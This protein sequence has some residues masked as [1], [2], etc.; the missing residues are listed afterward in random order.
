MRTGFADPIAPKPGKKKK[1]PWNF[2]CPPYDE[3]SSCYVNAG[4]HWGLGHRNPVGHKGNPTS[5]V[6]TLPRGRP[7]TMKVTEIPTAN[8][9][10]E[11]L[12]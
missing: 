4:S 1:S 2:T 8:L 6:P 11:Y 5:I 9:E 3:R 7:P 10:Q 12:D